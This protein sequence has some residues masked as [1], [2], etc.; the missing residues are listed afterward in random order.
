[1]VIQ[2]KAL[3]YTYHKFNNSKYYCVY[4]S[5]VYI[6]IPVSIRISQGIVTFI[7]NFGIR[8]SIF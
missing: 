3:L 6:K 2:E 1:M 5:W 8:R 4:S 7:A